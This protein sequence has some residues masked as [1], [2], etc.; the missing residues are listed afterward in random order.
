M[1]LCLQAVGCSCGPEWIDNPP[2]DDE[3]LYAVG[4]YVDS[5]YPEDNR[6]NAVK[7]ARIAL[8]KQVHTRVVSKLVDIRGLTWEQAVERAE[9]ETDASVKNS[10][11]VYYWTDEGGCRPNGKTG[12]VYVLLKAPMPPAMKK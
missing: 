10:Q 11:P 12:T 7:G 3:Y 2:Y 1:G 8:A 4:S 9:Q 6:K 5:Y